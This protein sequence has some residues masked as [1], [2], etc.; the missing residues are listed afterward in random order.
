MNKEYFKTAE[1]A[2][3]LRVSMSKLWKMCSKKELSYY[4]VG[5]LN[6]F[7]KDDLSEFI[8]KNRVLPISEL[9][10]KADEKLYN[11]K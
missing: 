8:E 2:E 6:L 4:K 9:K 7:K 1:A 5:R 3:F 11:I 10:K